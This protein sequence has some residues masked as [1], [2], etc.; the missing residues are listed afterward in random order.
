MWAAHQKGGPP[1]GRDEV[2]HEVGEVP[3]GSPGTI[4]DITRPPE[5]SSSVNATIERGQASWDR[6]PR[7][8]FGPAV[9]PSR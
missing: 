6:A 9:P 4:L 3:G 7:V 8:D 2:L 5:K 1:V